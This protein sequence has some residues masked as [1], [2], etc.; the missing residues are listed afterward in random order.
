RKHIETM[1]VQKIVSFP[2]D[3]MHRA[4]LHLHR[5]DWMRLRAGPA[6]VDFLWFTF[7]TD[8][9]NFGRCGQGPDGDRHRVAF[10]FDV[11]DIVKEE[12]LPLALVEAAK[13]P[14]NQRHQLR[15]LV[16]PPLDS[17]E[18]SALLKSFQMFSDVF[19]VALCLHE[20]SFCSRRAYGFHPLA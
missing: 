15:V 9:V 11:K 16:D 4:A 12:I 13:L 2:D 14:A 19:V 6:L 1:T 8:A 7:E 3:L 5:R 10:A 17:D 18:F 20:C